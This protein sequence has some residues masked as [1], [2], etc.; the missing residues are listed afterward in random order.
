M[1]NFRAC[2]C[3]GNFGQEFQARS[4]QVG[5]SLRDNRA[6]VSGRYMSPL[7]RSGSIVGTCQ[8][9]R[10]NGL[11]APAL[12]LARPGGTHHWLAVPRHRL[13]DN[14]WCGCCMSGLRNKA[15]P[16]SVVRNVRTG[17]RRSIRSDQ[18]ILTSDFDS[19]PNSNPG[20]AMSFPIRRAEGNAT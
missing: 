12:S 11:R 14:R 9:R 7:K 5:Q 19:T 15:D 1:R 16:T 4:R 6:R 20:S 13:C 10:D 2:S 8:S 18:R 3:L 17:H